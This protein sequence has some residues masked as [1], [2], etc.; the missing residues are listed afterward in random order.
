MQEGR[1]PAHIHVES[2]GSEAK[3]WLLPIAQAFS[4]GYADHELRR[5]EAII[6]ENL[7]VLQDAWERVHHR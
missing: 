2:G 5:V 7:G 6:T 1:E 4:R 3:F